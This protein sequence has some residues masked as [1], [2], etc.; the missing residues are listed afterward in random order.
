MI[1]ELLLTPIFALIK[2]FLGLMP[3]MPVVADF[4]S[5][6]I[7][8]ISKGLYFFPLPVWIACIGSIIFWSFGGIG[9]SFIEWI[10]KKIPGVD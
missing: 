6:G 1:I 2:G 9:W 7:S 3:S 5:S 10:Y 4:V 8:W